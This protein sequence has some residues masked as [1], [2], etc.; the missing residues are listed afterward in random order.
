MAAYQLLDLLRTQARNEHGRLD[1]RRRCSGR[2]HFY[3][4]RVRRSHHLVGIALRR[5]L[6]ILPA[7]GV[8]VV[9]VLLLDPLPQRTL[10]GEGLE[11]VEAAV[12]VRDRDRVRA[13]GRRTCGLPRAMSSMS[14]KLRR[15]SVGVETSGSRHG[16]SD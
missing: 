14:Q 7:L 12:R 5:L 9:V 10:R 2:C 11:V 4:A 15:R 3:C 16:A 6:D 8:V 1:R 13:S